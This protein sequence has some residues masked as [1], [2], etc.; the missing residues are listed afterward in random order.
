M[1]FMENTFMLITIGFAPASLDAQMVSLKNGPS[2]AWGVI[3]VLASAIDDSAIDRVPRKSVLYW[4]TPF[5]TSILKADTQTS[6]TVGKATMD[7]TS[8]HLR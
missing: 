3:A 2:G 7:S 1:S 4:R 6:K 5:D 8:I